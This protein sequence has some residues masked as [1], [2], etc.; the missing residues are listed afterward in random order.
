MH[1]GLAY[2]EA[3]VST[4]RPVIGDESALLQDDDVKAMTDVL[5]FPGCCDLF[6][7]VH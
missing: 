4:P 6:G 5:C 7:I 2:R 1:V 3:R